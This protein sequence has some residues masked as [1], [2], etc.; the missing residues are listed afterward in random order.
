MVMVYGTGPVSGGHL[1]PAVTLT[2][3][4]SEKFPLLDKTFLKSWVPQLRPPYSLGSR[5]TSPIEGWGTQGG[6]V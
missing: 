1:N 4:L 6:E 2:L 3:A 5:L